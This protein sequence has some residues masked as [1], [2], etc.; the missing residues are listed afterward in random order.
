MQVIAAMHMLSWVWLATHQ[1]CI[2]AV[3]HATLTTSK[4]V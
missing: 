2:T 1:L 3:V 4:G